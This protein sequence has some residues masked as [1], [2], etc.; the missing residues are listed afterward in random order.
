MFRVTASASLE[1]IKGF[2]I[3]RVS[4]VLAARRCV[5]GAAN[6]NAS[7]VQNPIPLQTQMC[8]GAEQDAIDEIICEV[9]GN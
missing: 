2:R 7:A 4:I 3:V 5:S 1:S 9:F 8:A 6:D